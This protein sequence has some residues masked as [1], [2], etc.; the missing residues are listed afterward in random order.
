MNELSVSKQESRKAYLAEWRKKNR[1]HL[2]T[3]HQDWSAKNKEHLKEYRSQP[4]VREQQREASRRYRT[5]NPVGKMLAI[6]KQAAKR[7]G[8]PF[9]LTKDDVVIPEFCPALGIL[10][11][12][13]ERLGPNTPS[14]DRIVPA[15][16]YVKGNVIVVS[17]LAN[18]I[19][20]DATAEQILAVGNFYAKLGGKGA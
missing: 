20:T 10:L 14:L 12:K 8:I 6:A 5:N 15:L 2:R 3:L 17:L 19:K 18:R 7:K 1:D 9:D 13:K 4:H 16:G 11:H